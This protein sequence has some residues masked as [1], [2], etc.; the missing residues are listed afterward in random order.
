[1]RIS[2]W[3]SDVCSSDLACGEREGPAKREGEGRSALAPHHLAILHHL[4][5]GIVADA[6]GE[7]GGVGDVPDHEVGGLAG[8]QGDRKSVV[9]G[10]RVSV[11][12]Y[13]GGR[14]IRKKKKQ[15]S[16]IRQR[17]YK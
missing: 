15:N 11:R 5:A 10:K 3:S 12:V 1:M 9:E 2:D 16:K 13:L 7:L 17:H 8:L 14:R 4:P 6:V